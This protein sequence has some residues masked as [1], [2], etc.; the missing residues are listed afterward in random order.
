VFNET[1]AMVFLVLIYVGTGSSIFL[2]ITYEIIIQTHCLMMTYIQRCFGHRIAGAYLH[3]LCEGDNILK[4][5]Q[6]IVIIMIYNVYV[7]H[8]CYA[9]IWACFTKAICLYVVSGIFYYIY[10]RF[11]AVS[12]VN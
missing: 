1:A 9:D 7:I 3:R 6:N 10:N 8:R 2:M 12:A 11:V 4:L 5:T